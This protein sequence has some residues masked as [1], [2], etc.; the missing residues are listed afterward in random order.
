LLG[1]FQAVD[2]RQLFSFMPIL[3]ITFFFFSFKFPIL[4][5]APF[6][7]LVRCGKIKKIFNVE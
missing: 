6:E 2:F 5:K 7:N 1:R 3:T 4:P